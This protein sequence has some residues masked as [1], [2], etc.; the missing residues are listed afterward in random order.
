LQAISFAPKKP[1][2]NLRKISIA[3]Q[4]AYAVDPAKGDFYRSVIDLRSDVKAEL[5][6]AKAQGRREDVA[7]LEMDQSFIKILANSTSYGIFVEIN[8]EEL[9]RKATVQCHT[10][11]GDPFAVETAKAEKL[12][13]YFHPLL[14]TLITGA[15]RLMLAITEH[16]A[17]DAGI[18]WAF[19]DTDSMAL[20]QP[21]GMPDDDFL[22]GAHFVRSWFDPLNPYQAK[23]DLLK[24]EDANLALDGLGGLAPLFCYAISA[25]RYALFNL[26]LPGRPVIRKASAHGLGHLMAPYGDG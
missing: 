10:G 13:P 4:P 23:S 3:G 21:T 15:A 11:N 25:K 26:D 7:Q 12:G 2:E 14:A 9:S 17:L 22:K 18:D 1:Q 19:C 8:V 6:D 24:I 16:L 5:K 20:A